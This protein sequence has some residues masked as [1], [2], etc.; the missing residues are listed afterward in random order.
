MN[1][2]EANDLLE[3]AERLAVDTVKLRDA[4][5]WEFLR[6][7]LEEVMSDDYDLG[8][9]LRIE[10]IFGG[11]VNVSCGIW[12]ETEGGRHKYFVRKYNDGISEPE[13]RF[14]HALVNHIIDRG[15]GLAAKVYP[16]RR[17]D[18]FATREEVRGGEKIKRFFAVY[19]CLDG[20]DKYDWF[21]NRL[22]DREYAAAARVLADF[23]H[24]AADFAPGDLARKQPPIMEFIPTLDGAFRAWA[25]D[26]RGT[27]FDE[28]Y[29]A[30]FA[31]IM[32]TLELGQGI[33][34]HDLEGTPMIPV[35]CDYHP[36]NLKWVAE[37][38][39]ALFDFDWSKIDYRT[40]DVGLAIA[41]FCT[42]WDGDDSG[43]AL[44][45]QD[46][47]LR[48]RLSGRVGQVHGP[49]AHGRERARGA[50]AHD[51]QRQP[52]RPQLGPERL[53]RRPR[54]GRRQVHQVPQAQ[55]HGPR[56]HRRASARADGAHAARSGG[57]HADR[58]LRHEHLP[59]RPQR[60]PDRNLEEVTEKRLSVP[61]AAK[62]VRRHEPKEA[63]TRAGGSQ[64]DARH[65]MHEQDVDEAGRSHGMF[66]TGSSAAHPLV[67]F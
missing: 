22:A 35:H 1:A 16:T 4:L 54:A 27:A 39:V 38:A 50:A 31:N 44:A 66:T 9:V 59:R 12:T 36:G 5:R 58:E 55:R 57:V 60:R 25:A 42:S 51:R 17:G 23:H 47:H 13:V 33:A 65:G 43:D 26:K 7:Q 32:R 67:G 6:Q 41:Y 11:A 34:G 2:D 63:D 8:R 40:F 61:P 53:L 48:A 10:Q 14:E 18:T 19:E 49:R 46:R 21:R 30:H 28:Y 24:C 20:E 52:V 56:I 62:P 45:R 37:Q 64:R 15:F 29:E 3:L